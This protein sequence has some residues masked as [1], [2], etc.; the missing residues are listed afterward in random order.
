MNKKEYQKKKKKKKNNFF[1]FNF[2]LII[3]VC[4]F[5]ETTS[6]SGTYS[7]AGC[8]YYLVYILKRNKQ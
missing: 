6:G 7:W 2:S 3:K 4:D 8:M 5:V 1:N